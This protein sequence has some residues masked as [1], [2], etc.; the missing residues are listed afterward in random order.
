[1]DS[2]ITYSFVGD[3]TQTLNTL[4]GRAPTQHTLSELS[5]SFEVN[6]LIFMNQPMSWWLNGL[7]TSTIRYTPLN[8]DVNWS[9]VDAN[10]QVFHI[11]LSISDLIIPNTTGT[12]TPDF[13][14]KIVTCVSAP[15]FGMTKTGIFTM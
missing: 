10:E 14:T 6:Q 8:N 12:C 11:G 9:Y 13:G 15:K 3:S 7:T 1:M 2:I 4:T 5:A